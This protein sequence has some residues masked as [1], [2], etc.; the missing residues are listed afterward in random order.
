[1]LYLEQVEI[2]A[3]GMG[4][5]SLLY[6]KTVV[7]EYDVF[8]RRLGRQRVP[9]A[10]PPLRAAGACAATASSGGCHFSP[11]MGFL[12]YDPA[13]SLRLKARDERDGGFARKEDEREWS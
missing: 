4:T 11:G 9:F 12:R 6:L 2:L 13:F 5:L 1:M 7:L 10:L 3:V 8:V